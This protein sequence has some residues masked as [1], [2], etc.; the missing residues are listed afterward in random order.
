MFNKE[1]KRINQLPIFSRPKCPQQ[2]LYLLKLTLWTVTLRKPLFSIP[3]QLC[4]MPAALSEK[5]V[6]RLVDNVSVVPYFSK[7]FIHI[8]VCNE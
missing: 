7:N 3:R 6:Q 4:M 1:S 5:N 8:S 2:C